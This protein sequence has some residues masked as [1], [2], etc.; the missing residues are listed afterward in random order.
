VTAGAFCTRCGASL[1]PTGRI[2]GAAADA[3]NPKTRFANF[4][5]HPGE[6]V[7]HPG[8]LSTLLPHVGHHKVHEFRYALIAGI[9]GVFILYLAGLIAAAVLVAAFLVPLLYLLY[10]YE[11]QVYRDEPLP[12]LALTFGG[13]IIVGIV[14]TLLVDYFSPSYAGLPRAATA[15]TTAILFIVVPIIQALVKPLPALPLLSR[16]KFRETVDGLVFGVAA[17]LGFSISETLIRYSDIINHLP[18]QTSPEN[19]IYPLLTLAVLR[20]LMLGSTA[21]AITAAIWRGAR[22]R[23]GTHEIGVIVAAV[24]VEVAFAWGSQELVNRHFAQIVILAWQAL[25]VGAIVV[26][27]RFVLHQALL[28]EAGDMGFVETVC[29]NCQQQVMAAGFCPHCG[30][31]MSAAPGQIRDA[32][33]ESSAATPTTQAPEGT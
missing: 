7:L 3:G 16:P 1:N 9:A 8:V 18:L 17:G 21:G 28:E 29:P 27:I 19:W 4:A 32:R 24:A 6:H 25:L 10:L 2:H 33:E 14:V 15:G 11:A 22:G 13:G 26:Y 12:V 30:M 20:P 5:A 31:A 23:L